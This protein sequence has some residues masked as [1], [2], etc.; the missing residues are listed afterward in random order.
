MELSRVV[1]C[2]PQ[3]R[4]ENWIVSWVKRRMCDVCEGVWP[5]SLQLRQQGT[6]RG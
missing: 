4:S 3:N 6:T 1:Y 5:V 2:G